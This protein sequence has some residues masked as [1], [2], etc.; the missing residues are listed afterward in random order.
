MSNRVRINLVDNIAKAASAAEALLAEAAI[1]FD[2][3]GANLSRFG[4]LG[5]MQFRS[6]SNVYICDALVPEVVGQFKAVLESEKIIKITHDCREDASALLHQ[7]RIYIRN[8]FDTQIAYRRLMNHDYLSSLEH[9]RSSVLLHTRPGLSQQ[10]SSDTWLRRPLTTDQVDYAVHDVVDALALY[11][12]LSERVSSADVDLDFSRY[13]GY[14]AM[15]VPQVKGRKDLKP[16]VKVQAMLAARAPNGWYFKLNCGIP[17]IV[18]GLERLARI[19]D[20]TVGEIT[21]CVV[22]AKTNIDDAVLLE[23]L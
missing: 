9:V 7:H 13:L 17:G 4:R 20:L 21:P 1:G 16:G 8:I 6:P 10:D 19:H 18:S 14:R 2:S 5:L 3:E 15:N 23:P 12:A 22:I 11:T